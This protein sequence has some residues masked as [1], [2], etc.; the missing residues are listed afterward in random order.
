VAPT[1]SRFVGRAESTA[2]LTLNATP[3]V[4]SIITRAMRV[5]ASTPYTLTWPAADAAGVLKS[6]GAGA[7][8]FGLG[9]PVLNKTATYSLLTTDGDGVLVLVDATSGPV[10]IDLYTAVGNSGR[11]VTVKKSDASTNVVTVDPNGAETIDGAAT[12]G[13]PGQYATLT[14]QA[15]GSNW[16]SRGGTALTA[17]GTA[18]SPS[19]SF[20]NN[21]DNGMYLAAADD[22][23]FS[24][25]G[26]KAL[27]IDS[28]QFI[29][30]PTQPRASVRKASTDTTTNESAAIAFDTEDYDVGAWHTGSGTTVTVPTGGTGLYLIVASTRMASPAANSER[31]LR[32]KKNGATILAGS[33]G[34]TTGLPFG[35]IRT[36][37]VVTLAAADALTVTVDGGGQST[38]FGDGTNAWNET[39]L[40]VVKLW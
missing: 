2:A 15:D 24:T 8:S 33:L 17:N 29:D 4:A 36:S 13:L 27:E 40:T 26:V 6:D 5:N 34:A 39:R 21:A 19:H 25:G 16:R 31:V 10:T 14:I 7:L 11:L 35:T 37:D 32:V 28:T 1:N 38:D 12:V 30:S 18:A 9:A 22:I 23:A 20:Q 3:T